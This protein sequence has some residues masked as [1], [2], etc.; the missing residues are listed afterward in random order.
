MLQGRYRS[1]GVLGQGGMGTVYR[2]EDTSTGQRLALKRLAE[3]A[4]ERDRLRFRREFHTL[5]QLRHPSIVEAH[6]FG[7]DGDGLYYTME[8]LEGADLHELGLLPL[9]RALD[10]LLQMAS[11]L[12]FLHARR[13]VHRDVATRNIRLGAGGRAKLIDFGI[14]AT[15]GA[16]AEVAGTPPYVAPECFRG[17]PLDH[18]ADLFA[19]GA[20]A[21]R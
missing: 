9:D 10:V 20:L 17:L 16:S 21:Y 5:S 18:R 8:L 1:T 19:L 4:T 7:V 3:P 11:A 13:L 6:E 12:A 14:L 15:A 2:V